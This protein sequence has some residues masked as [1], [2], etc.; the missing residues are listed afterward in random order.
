MGDG[1][2]PIGHTEPW[3]ILFLVDKD[4]YKVSKIKCIFPG[5]TLYF[6]LL[7]LKFIYI[8]NCH[9]TCFYFPLFSY[10]LFLAF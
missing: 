6:L 8:F 10:I 9:F 4:D 5:L 1:D 3:E 2:L 7:L